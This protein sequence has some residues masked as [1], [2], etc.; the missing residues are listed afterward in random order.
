MSC[1]AELSIKKFINSGPDCYL[2]V[3]ILCLHKKNLEYSFCMPDSP[4]WFLMSSAD[5]LF[6]INCFKK[7]LGLLSE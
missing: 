3:H 5:L 6:K 7:Y 1:S 4:S 2:R